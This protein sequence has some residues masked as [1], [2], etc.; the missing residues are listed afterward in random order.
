MKSIIYKKKVIVKDTILNVA[1]HLN[2]GESQSNDTD[3]KIIIH[4]DSLDFIY[5]QSFNSPTIEHNIDQCIKNSLRMISKHK[6]TLNKLSK[7][8]QDANFTTTIYLP[9]F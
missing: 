7:Y 1:V 9:S 6:E 2:V 8:L 5:E 3:Y 4:E